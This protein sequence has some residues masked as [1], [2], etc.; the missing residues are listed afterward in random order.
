[1]ST[2]SAFWKSCSYTISNLLE[3]LIK[4]AESW[5]MSYIFI[6]IKYFI[7]PLKINF[8]EVYFPVN[9][10]HKMQ[11]LS[12][13]VLMNM[14]SHVYHQGIK[15]F[16]HPESFLVFLC[17]PLL[18]DIIYVSFMFALKAECWRI[19]AFELW[20]W[21]RLLRVPWTARRSNQSILQEISPGISLEGMMLKLKL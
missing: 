17:C 13:R 9:T 19:D 18:R 1:M 11:V 10:I 16:Y 7:T 6:H 3:I 21:R 2:P 12:C 14:Y 20:C 5:A 4:D 8:I 15:H